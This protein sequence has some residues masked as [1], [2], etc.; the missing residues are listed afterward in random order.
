MKSQVIVLKGAD[1]CLEV[2]EITHTSLRGC[3][4]AWWWLTVNGT[5][6]HS[7]RC[8]SCLPFR[9]ES[10]YYQMRDGRQKK[11]LLYQE[12]YGPSFV[13]W[14]VKAETRSD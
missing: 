5:A 11:L 6:V 14:G 4:E 13:R 12:Q 2:D 10:Y 7:V 1:W 3:K 9:V 8:C